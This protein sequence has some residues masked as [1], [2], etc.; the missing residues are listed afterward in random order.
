MKLSKKIVAMILVTAMVIAQVSVLPFATE[1][2][3]SGLGDS[4]SYALKV[5]ELSSVGYDAVGSDKV[6]WVQSSKTLGRNDDNTDYASNIK[7][8]IFIASEGGER[9]FVLNPKSSDAYVTFKNATTLTYTSD[10]ITNGLPASI[11]YSKLNGMAFRLKG[12]GLVTDKMVF[13]LEL[14]NKTGTATAYVAKSGM[15]FINAADGVVSNV[16]YTENG[17]ELAGNVDGWLYVPFTGFVDSSNKALSS[18]KA[19]FALTT[20][21]NTGYRG[22]KFTFKTD[23]FNGKELYSGNAMFVES[24]ESFRKVHGTPEPATAKS[25]TEDSITLNT[26]SGVEYSI[27]GKKWN[28][29]G[30]FTG[31][32]EGKKY[33]V[34]ARYK[35]KTN[36]SSA[37]I[38]T[39]GLTDIELVSSTYNSLTI[40]VVPGQEYRVK[41]VTQW[42]T[43]PVFEGLEGNTEY[44]INT[45][46]IG[47]TTQKKA[48]FKT[49][50]YPW[51]TG[52]NE[53]AYYAL[54]V[55][56]KVTELTGSL[57]SATGSIASLP[58][59]K[60]DGVNYIALSPSGSAE[61]AATI[62]AGA[63]TYGST[64]YGLPADMVKNDTFIG[65]AFRLNVAGGT[66]GTASTF[67]ISLFDGY[68]IN[69]ADYKFIDTTDGSVSTITYD[70][71]FT[72]SD[73]LDGWVLIPFTSIIKGSESLAPSYNNIMFRNI[74]FTLYGADKASDWTNRTLSVGTVLF[75]A[76]ETNFVRAYSVPVAPE[77]AERTNS[78]IALNPMEGVEYALDGS[79]E[80]T[81]EGVFE[82]L[83]AGTEY[84]FKVRYVG[85]TDYN[86]VVVKTR[87]AKPT[88]VA[89]T[90]DDVVAGVTTITVI[91]P[92]EDNLYSVDGGKTWSEDGIFEGLAS[93]TSWELIAKIYGTDKYTDALIVKTEKGVYSS[94]YSDSASF[95]TKVPTASD[96]TPDSVGEYITKDQNNGI[97]WAAGFAKNGKL[98]IEQI[99]GK[100]MICI[101]ADS[102]VKG[103]IS[104][105]ITYEGKAYYDGVKGLPAEIGLS[106]AFAFRVV[107]KGG[108]A[109]Q[110][111][112]LDFY[113]D[114]AGTEY[115]PKYDG[116]IQYIDAKTGW[117]SQLSYNNGIK[118]TGELDGWIVIPESAYS[119]NA[120][121]FGNAMLTD[122]NGINIQIYS[123][124][125]SSWANGKKLYLG[126][127]LFVADANKFLEIHSAPVVPSY[128]E[129]DSQSITL[130]TIPGVEYWIE[131]K[132]AE[133]NTTGVFT[134]LKEN[135]EYT[136][137]SKY[138]KNDYISDALVV[139]TDMKNPPMT[140]PELIGTPD[141]YATVKVV[142]G[143][144]YSID[145]TNWTETGVFGVL[146]PGT[147]YEIVGK[148]KATGK[149][150]AAVKFTTLKPE[151]IYD[152]G[153]GSSDML[154]ISRYDGQNY[155]NEYVFSETLGLTADGLKASQENGGRLEI[156]EVD[157]ERFIQ[158]KIHTNYTDHGNFQLGHTAH[159]GVEGG[160]PR[161]IWL[162]D[163][164]GFAIRMKNERTD[165]KAQFFALWYRL[166]D[167]EDTR[168]VPYPDGGR[169]YYTIDMKTGTWKREVMNGAL[170]MPGGFDGWL[171]LPFEVYYERNGISVELFQEYWRSHQ[172]YLRQGSGYANSNW[173][174]YPLLVG[175]SV[176]IEDINLFMETYAPNTPD[177]LVTKP[178]NITTDENI[179]GVMSNDGTG[180]A[181]FN[182]L[183]TLSGAT[184]TTEEIKKPNETS[185]ALSV[186]IN[187][188]GNIGVT[189]DALNYEDVPEELLSTV[190][191]SFGYS[192]YVNIPKTV[193]G[194]VGFNLEVREE[195]TEYFD[196]NGDFYYTI[197]GGVATKH[198]G[199]FELEPGF[200][201]V[202]VVPFD[203]F[204][205]NATYSTYV[206]GV[207][208]TPHLVDYYGLYFD[209]DKYP[210]LKDAT[211]YL[212]DFYL[213]QNLEEYITY[214]LKVQGT[215]EYSIVDNPNTY[216]EEHEPTFPRNM[217]N[218]CTGI[219]IGKGIYSMDN[220]T[221][222]LVDKKDIDDS[223]INIKIGDGS[224][225][226]M[227]ENRAY[228]EDI[229][230]EEY[231]KLMSSNGISFWVSVPEDAPM[232][233]GLDLELLEDDSE[234]F[235]YNPNTFYYTVED[236][237][238]YQ[239]YGYLEFKPGFEG[240]V[241]I[242]F[243]S[244]FFD[245]F[246]STVIDGT[247]NNIDLIDYFG[248]YFDTENYASIAGT[249][250][251]VDDF[252]FYQGTYRFIDAVWAKQTGNGIT[253]VS[254]EYYSVN[255]DRILQVAEVTNQI[256]LVSRNT[257]GI[258]DATAPIVAVSG[259][260]IL[261][262][263]LIVIGRKKRTEEN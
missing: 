248:F 123:S 41:G 142:P 32:E 214:M 110:L 188:S 233:V 70:G 225:T 134:G 131:G 34:L 4:A 65:F 9:F 84:T 56:D 211:I 60:K 156:V 139:T 238:V 193:S 262:A 97:D 159:Y 37:S 241:V 175:D 130:V 182:G 12:K 19:G 21:N 104:S 113:F 51:T 146:D 100:R 87:L 36:A 127:A 246:S 119:D 26:V 3:A 22:I 168:E 144:T 35:G 2:Y 28:T 227:F 48:E 261:S 57:G 258:G 92:V 52:N 13:D 205:Y 184:V 229:S 18:A 102:A 23:D 8:K 169:P 164:W 219:E 136:I 199:K 126:D 230:D 91:N 42:Q 154:P 69:N 82:G 207:L 158:Y 66:K 77:V 71:G 160:F 256:E 234:Y 194:K 90:A 108:E 44:T 216:R 55:S 239:V 260:A 153:D 252:A 49:A 204:N 226:V 170:R 161:S 115:Y 29:D 251:S 88:L 221:L 209:T 89:P 163:F 72:V 174:D 98:Y 76:D 141:E 112:A 257:A 236:G 145:G 120:A 7:G 59:S 171:L 147:E 50:Q 138:T 218:D 109:T 189:N 86:T 16:S 106:K 116:A 111:S 259:L 96:T 215:D 243:E 180:T 200:N 220:V 195:G 11:D 67:N 103:T 61:G 203:N 101:E 129:K 78:S 237:K 155:F 185:T 15:L 191:G 206:N 140:A 242:P 181:L 228:W 143:I 162:K 10:S 114:L 20:A 249:T 17:I 30:K 33:T 172:I 247:L 149:L 201:G 83:K 27:N 68:S 148:N 150:T 135:T 197:T 81:A 6:G 165:D 240:M 80:W 250:I 94:G 43:T 14:T 176:V 179:P 217:A 5:P 53:D 24:L 121:Y 178:H 223:Y 105:N 187:G 38:Y 107:V 117:V 255:A 99:D 54:N 137:L 196:Y 263:A 124:S 39:K 40:I 122:Y 190:K 132:E 167:V 235:I 253:E 254:P 173:K 212:D 192:F 25:T 244:F 118:F 93:D 75:Y 151:N 232:T 231:N 177:K 213:Y 198:Y 1:N 208:F 183:T 95:M 63:I 47:E 133:K 152:R 245:E 186:K 73:N 202:V 157:G 46:I 79:D 62:G 45:R 222:S 58:V 31:L 125:N 74:G 224:S 210:A 85:R 166:S 128:A 64:G